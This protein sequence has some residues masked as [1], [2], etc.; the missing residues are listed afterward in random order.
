M[1]LYEIK[2]ADVIETIRSFQMGTTWKP[3]RHEVLNRDL[4]AKYGHPLKVVFCRE[5]DTIL[6][7]T[8]YPLKRGRKNEDSL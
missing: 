5:H 2:E 4:S 3:G 7:I 6:V 8:A 1:Q